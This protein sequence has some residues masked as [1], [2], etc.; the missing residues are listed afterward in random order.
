MVANNVFMRPNVNN[1][2]FFIGAFFSRLGQKGSAASSG[3]PGLA[4]TSPVL[5]GRTN[6][7]VKG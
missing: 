7:D 5:M 6:K 3:R 4:N 1:A 2:S